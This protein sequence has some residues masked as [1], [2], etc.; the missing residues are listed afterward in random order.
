MQRAEPSLDCVATVTDACCVLQCIFAFHVYFTWY[1][2]D[3]IVLLIAIVYTY[4]VVL[5]LLVSFMPILD[6]LEIGIC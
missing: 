3:I 1:D 4:C 2:I 5:A 6:R